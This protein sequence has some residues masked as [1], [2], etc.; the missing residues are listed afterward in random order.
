VQ[1][2]LD[3]IAFAGGLEDCEVETEVH[4]SY[5]GYRFKRDDDVV[6]IA[7]TALERSGF[8]P[9]YALSGGGADANVF[10]ERGLRCLNL[11]NGMQDIHT[12]DERI[13]VDDLE[14]MVDVTLALLDVAREHAA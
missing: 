2:T 4:K 6:R 7:H 11:A 8:T 12:P 10:N 3:A 14:R 13:A 9:T 5:R 1:E